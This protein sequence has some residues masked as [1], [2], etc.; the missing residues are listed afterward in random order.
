[1]ETRTDRLKALISAKAVTPWP[2][3]PGI[4]FDQQKAV[5]ALLGMYG[6]DKP[7]GELSAS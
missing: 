2:R 6:L 3:R 1:M 5:A 7:A 4:H